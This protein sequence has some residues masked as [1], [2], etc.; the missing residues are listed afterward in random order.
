MYI[1]LRKHNFNKMKKINIKL[2]WLI[3]VLLPL[4]NTTILAQGYG[5][6]VGVRVGDGI[7]FTVKQQI[8]LRATAEL[9]LQKGFQS[10]STTASILAMRHLNFLTRAANFY[11]GAG[12]HY[13]SFDA[14]ENKANRYGI[15]GIVG[16]EINI[17]NVNI[18]ADYKP[19][20]NFN[21]RPDLSSTGISIRY[22][23]AGRYIKDDSWKFWKKK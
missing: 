12:G 20:I 14:S 8:A 17:G 22:I 2:F 10:N 6:A 11:V 16:F 13:T 7:G 18:S 5:T 4:S 21:A 3:L 23:I 9:I 19:R 15:S 1:T